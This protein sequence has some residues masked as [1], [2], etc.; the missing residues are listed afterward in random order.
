MA[1]VILSPGSWDAQETNLLIYW[2]WMYFGCYMSW[3]IFLS[4]SFSPLFTDAPFV[5]PELLS[6]MGAD[7]YTVSSMSALTYKGQQWSEMERKK[8]TH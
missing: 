3:I 5:V 8:G 1:D 7:V 4:H 2:N 6:L